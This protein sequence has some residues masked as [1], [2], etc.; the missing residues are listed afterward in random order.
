M[1]NT[2]VDVLEVLTHE[3]NAI[4]ELEPP[5]GMWDRFAARLDAEEAEAPVAV[6]RT[7]RKQVF[8]RGLSLVPT[9]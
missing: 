9:R 8:L 6:R 5:A 2:M 7:A 4:A 3:M 1:K